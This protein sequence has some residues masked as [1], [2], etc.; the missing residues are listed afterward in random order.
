MTRARV[1][2]AGVLA[3]AGCLSK[4]T[5]P[6]QM[7]VSRKWRQRIPTAMSAPGNVVNPRL[8]YDPHRGVLLYDGNNDAMWQL[9]GATND[10]VS[11]CKPLQCIGMRLGLVGFVYDP[12]Q[13]RML[14]F[15]GCV[16]N[17]CNQNLYAWDGNP[18][19][20]L[21]VAP[22]PSGRA[23][24]AMVVDPITNHTIVVGGVDPVNGN[25]NDAWSFDGS[26]W[27]M[28]S[29]LGLVAFPSTEAA[30]DPDAGDILVF[31]DNDMSSLFALANGNFAPICQNCMSDGLS[32]SLTSLVHIADYDQTF[33]IDSGPTM[34]ELVGNPPRFVPYNDQPGPDL[35]RSG[36]AYD[37][38]RDAVVFYGNDGST[39]ELTQ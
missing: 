9:S 11:L 17:A 2:L 39:W 34:Y 18:W 38:G 13:A 5:P 25:I 29:A 32:H 22:G 30:A 3:A 33:L 28:I 24:M 23:Q 37:A 4:P 6:G 27:S 8:A 20:M 19:R 14:L 15:G 1:A 31:P 16:N 10:W 36:A 12:L 7:G 26:T 21:P 35:D